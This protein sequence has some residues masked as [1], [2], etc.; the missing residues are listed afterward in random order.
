MSK[1]INPNMVSNI[2]LDKK[3]DLEK[4]TSSN[5][6]EDRVSNTRAESDTKKEKGREEDNLEKGTSSNSGE[7]EKSN[8]GAESNT[9]EEPKDGRPSAKWLFLAY[10]VVF[11][12]LG[13][14][15]IALYDT[16]KK[17]RAPFDG[18]ADGFAKKLLYAFNLPVVIPCLLVLYKPAG[19]MQMLKEKYQKL[20]ESL[21]AKVGLVKDS[22]DK[23][24]GE[25]GL[26]A[27]LEDNDSINK[28]KENPEEV[29]MKKGEDLKG[30]VEEKANE[31]ESLGNTSSNVPEAKPEE[32]SVKEKEDSKGKLEEKDNEVESLSNTSSNAPEAKP[33]EKDNESEEN[34]D[35]TRQ[36]VIP[37]EV[38]E[39]SQ[40]SLSMDR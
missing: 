27:N 39:K 22:I 14:W 6:I 3:D 17:K 16:L 5:S 19:F 4:G 31:V 30:K 7:G 26:L 24:L 12:F 2:P 23:S 8:T 37:E 20:V 9:K 13:L 35:K 32:A 11:G 10:I 21:G 18:F 38:K 29:S 15:A 34:I 36:K 25:D 33:E 28:K 1:E 40:Q